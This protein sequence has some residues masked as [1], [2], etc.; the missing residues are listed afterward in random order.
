[1]PNGRGLH[2]ANNAKPLYLPNPV[3]RIIGYTGVFNDYPTVYFTLGHYTQKHEQKWD[4]GWEDCEGWE[5]KFFGNVR[6]KPPRKD[7]KAADSFHDVQQHSLFSKPDDYVLCLNG[8]GKNRFT[9]TPVADNLSNWNLNE[10][11]DNNPQDLRLREFWIRNGGKKREDLFAHPSRGHFIPLPINDFGTRILL[12]DALRARL[13]TGPS[14]ND[15][16]KTNKGE[17]RLP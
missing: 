2:E 13:R 7:G 17:W 12:L 16:I 9:G 11:L 15:L 4:V 10:N 6:S 5:C 1:M 3:P 8:L 14:P